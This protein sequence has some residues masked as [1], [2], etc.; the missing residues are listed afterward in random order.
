MVEIGNTIIRTLVAIA[1]PEITKNI[2]IPT[3]VANSEINLFSLFLIFG[4]L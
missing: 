2:I 4:L 1:I 3:G